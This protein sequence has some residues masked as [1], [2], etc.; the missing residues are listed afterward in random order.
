MFGIGH[1]DMMPLLYGDIMFLGIWSIWHKL[2]TGHPVKAC[3]ELIVFIGVFALHG[4]TLGGG[5]AAMVCALIAGQTLFRVKKPL[6]PYIRR[7]S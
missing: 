7:N 5:F 1:V 4:G 3:G 2:V 6:R